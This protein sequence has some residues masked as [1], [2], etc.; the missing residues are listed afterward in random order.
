LVLCLGGFLNL[1]TLALLFLFPMTFDPTQPRTFLALWLVQKYRRR[2]QWMAE[3]DRDDVDLEAN[4][5]PMQ[6]Q[7]KSALIT[8]L[9][10]QES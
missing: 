1:L 5:V 6:L 10:E 2:K 7:G 9:M 3:S 4:C 8:P